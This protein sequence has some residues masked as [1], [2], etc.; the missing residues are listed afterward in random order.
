VPPEL[1]AAL[2]A[3][4]A[5]LAAFLRTEVAARRQRDRLRD[6]EHKVGADRRRSDR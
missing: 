6:V 2:T 5:A 4:A 1:V 3:L